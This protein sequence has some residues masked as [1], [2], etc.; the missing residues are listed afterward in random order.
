MEICR[1][2]RRLAFVVAL[3]ITPILGSIGWKFSP[4]THAYLG[5]FAYWPILL[6]GT[7]FTTAITFVLYFRR[8]FSNRVILIPSTI[9]GTC[10]LCSFLTLDYRTERK[11]LISQSGLRGIVYEDHSGEFGV[12]LVFTV[13][14]PNGD[15]VGEAYLGWYM[16]PEE[17]DFQIRDIDAQLQ[18]VEKTEP[19]RVLAWYSPA[20]DR[21]LSYRDH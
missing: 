8:T 19:N 6:I 18:V 1:C 4:G 16:T 17:V 3:T 5:A 7:I 9:I 14:R 15:L 21:V 11:E 10:I 12:E 20:T 2:F 13:M